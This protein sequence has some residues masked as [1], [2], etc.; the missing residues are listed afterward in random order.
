LFYELVRFRRPFVIVKCNAGADDVQ[1]RR[2]SMR[3]A[4]LNERN[5]LLRVSRKRSAHITTAEIQCHQAKIDAL[6]GVNGSLLLN[7]SFIGSRRELPFRESVNAVIL[8][9]I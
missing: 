8:N 1:N 9:H 7:G 6:K 4:A 2:S 3:K 5:H